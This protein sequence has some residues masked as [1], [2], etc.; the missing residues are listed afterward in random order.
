VV[1]L[2]AIALNRIGYGMALISAFSAGLAAVLVG[3][4][5]LVVSAQGLLSRLPSGGGW[6]RKLPVA[7]ALVITMIGMLLVARALAQV[8]P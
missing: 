5:I 8:A 3:I 4:G 7:S 2:S 6:M 1:L